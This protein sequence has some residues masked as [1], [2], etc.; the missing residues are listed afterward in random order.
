MMGKKVVLSILNPDVAEYVNKNFSR[1]I[2]TA[3]VERK[4]HG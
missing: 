1:A 4:N 2:K 3:V